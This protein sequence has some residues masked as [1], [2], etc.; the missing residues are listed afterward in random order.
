MASRA[1]YERSRAE[2]ESVMA[3]YRADNSRQQRPAARAH[4][5]AASSSKEPPARFFLVQRKGPACFLIADASALGASARVSAPD[6][7]WRTVLRFT[8]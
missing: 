6:N 3:S 1:D 5:P 4:A 7:P 8:R 2:Y